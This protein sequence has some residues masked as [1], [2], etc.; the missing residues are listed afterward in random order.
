MGARP[1]RSAAMIASTAV[2]LAALFFATFVALPAAAKRD[3]RDKGDDDMLRAASEFANARTAPGIV[4]PGAYSAAFASLQALPSTAGAWTEVTT[5]PYNSDDLR[6]RDPFAS[7]ATGGSG[8]VAG[9]MTGLAAGGGFLF[10]GGARGGGFR[11]GGGGDNPGPV[12]GGVAAA[13]L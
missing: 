8:F 1:R 13:F 5:R 6:Y 11:P 2:R 12:E 4:L 3:D 7:N 10:S 9:R